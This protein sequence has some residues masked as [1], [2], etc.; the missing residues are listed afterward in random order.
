MSTCTYP[1]PACLPSSAMLLQVQSCITGLICFPQPI[2][3]KAL[4]QA[5]SGELRV[6]PSQP[7]FPS[8]ADSNRA[9]HPSVHLSVLPTRTH[10]RLHS[11]WPPSSVIL[12][13]HLLL[14]S[15]PASQPAHS[16]QPATQ[17]ADQ[18]SPPCPG[19]SSCPHV[20]QVP[21]AL[22]QAAHPALSCSIAAAAKGASNVL[23]DS[24]HIG[25]LQCGTQTMWCHHHQNRAAAIV[26]QGIDTAVQ[27]LHKK[28][29][30]EQWQGLMP[31][32]LYGLQ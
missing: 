27:H 16:C 12:Q 1:L 17:P 11:S 20:L 24:T 18:Q 31:L 19:C 29:K 3:G 23:K 25:S 14:L 6:P 5:G 7:L 21:V 28:K 30:E 8:R 2:L 4:Q 9:N 32:L 26:Y 10:A 22:Q 15:Q 13:V